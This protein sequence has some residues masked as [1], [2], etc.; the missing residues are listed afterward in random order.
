M[1]SYRT[2][3]L[4]T[5]PLLVLQACA[6][7][8]PSEDVTR[9]MARTDAVIQQADR[10][11]VAVNALPEL[12][13]AKDKYAQ[14]KQELARKSAESD[15]RALQLAKEAEVDANY[16]NA[17]AQSETQEAATE[18]VQKGVETLRQESARAAATP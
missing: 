18:Q 4:I 13:K 15:R 8:R 9:Q 2:A 3:A 14:A 17:R 1:K 7:Y 16:A 6:S 10:S 11:N 12:Q 5:L